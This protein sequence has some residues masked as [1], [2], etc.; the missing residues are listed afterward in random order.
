M[1]RYKIL[2]AASGLLLLVA[3]GS[4]QPRF[5]LELVARTGATGFVP[6][7][8]FP[9][10]NSI[11]SYRPSINDNGVVAIRMEAGANRA[12][13]RGTSLGGDVVATSTNFISDVWINASGDIVWAEGGNIQRYS[14]AFGTTSL[15]TNLPSGSSSV[16]G[17]RLNN[18]GTLGYRATVGSSRL[19]GVFDPIP[20]PC[21][22][23]CDGSSDCHR[24]E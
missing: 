8:N 23:N 9:I 21:E 19:T 14:A 17:L 1:K 13:W 15:Y 24:S 4:S 22:S 7:F 2:C 3:V 18:D 10:N 16:G 5:D 12:I 6:A 20:Q 11:S